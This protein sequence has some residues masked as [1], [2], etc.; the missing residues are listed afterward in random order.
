MATA[1]ITAAVTPENEP[2]HDGW[3]L[4]SVSFRGRKALFRKYSPD[5]PPTARGLFEDIHHALYRLRNEG[6]LAALAVLG[7]VE[8]GATAS[9][10]L[11]QLMADDRKIRSLLG[12]EL[13]A[14]Y[15]DMR[16]GDVKDSLA[17]I[18]LAKETIGYEPVMY[19]DEGLETSIGWYKENL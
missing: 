15:T 9:E 7:S 1:S 3:W 2:A 11:D 10:T 18:S 5:A 6:P 12:V 16:P 13:K 4:L 17:D 19:F 14:E 8:G